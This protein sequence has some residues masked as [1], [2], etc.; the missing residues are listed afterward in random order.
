MD[1]LAAQGRKHIGCMAGDLN[2]SE[3]RERY[4]TFRSGLA[5]HGIDFPDR[6]FMPCDLSEQ[7]RDE[8]EEL[9]DRAPELDAIV[10]AN[11]K[12]AEVT[13]ELLKERGKVVGRDVA[14]TGF[15]DLPS[16]A[17]LTPPLATV[18]ADAEKLG[19]RAVEKV[20]NKLNGVPD[21]MTRFPTEFIRRE[22][23]DRAEYRAKQFERISENERQ[24]LRLQSEQRTHTDNIFIRDA[25]MF[26]ADIKHSYAKAMKQ[27]S[28][29]G[30]V[31]GFIY[32][33]EKPLTHR[34]GEDFPRGQTWLFRSYNYGAD[35][36]TV[37]DGEQ[38][39]DIRSVFHNKYLCTNRQHCFVV[40][41]LYS[42]DTQYGIALL[43]P[44]DTGFF[45]ELE[46]ATY[47]LSSAV[48]TLD[49]LH[50]QEKLL[51]RLKT[52]NM[53]L[54]KESQIDELTGIYNR[55]GFYHAADRLF[56]ETGSAGEYLICYADM[57]NLK[58]VND[59]YGH[60]EGDFSLRLIAKC[61]RKVFGESAVIGRLGG[62]EYAV[63]AP[64]AERSPEEY[65]TEKDSFVAEFNESGAK[66]YRFGLS[67][68]VLR[69]GCEN[70]YDLKAALD[71]ADDLL[72]VQKQ[73]RKKEI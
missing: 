12:I 49:I 31:T 34:Y 51:G 17:E 60:N 1:E 30:A 44:K 11:D 57:D 40:A 61:L 10:C 22:S 32:T 43:E 9:L 71:K 8:V 42:A 15:D 55:R 27:L 70:G 38:L 37:P 39:M 58:L 59:V 50:S 68:G 20:I 16:S 66:P 53:A 14:V 63:I 25:M 2:N 23:V 65:L 46:L 19:E 69:C 52:V 62:D 5:G 64:A 26:T 67:M 72:Y 6:Y 7:C 56:E 36:F 54:E 73:K 35:T 4:E 33:L 41:D 24:Q 28:L 13:Y 47:I 45:S 3:C 48:R 21:D 18:R 29:I